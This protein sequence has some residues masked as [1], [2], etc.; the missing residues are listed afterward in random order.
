M[1]V[2]V[3]GGVDSIA[4]CHYLM[5]KGYNVKVF[6]FNHKTSNVN[7]EMQ[8]K[9]VNFALNFNLEFLVKNREDSLDNIS[10][11]KEAA[12]RSV[13][14]KAYNQLDGNI[15]LGHHLDDCVESYLFNC[16]KGNPEYMP[17]PHVTLLDN[18]FSLFRP[19]MLVDKDLIVDYIKKND[20]EKFVCVDPTNFDSNYGMRNWIRNELIPQISVRYKGLRTVVRKRIVERLKGSKGSRLLEEKHNL[21]WELK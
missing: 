17:I 20:L 10:T 14:I 3:S 11:S 8:N 7:E 13:R 12:L 15:A 9:V 4:V 18:G 2:A 6:H 1:W 5:T 16:L 21:A 19:F